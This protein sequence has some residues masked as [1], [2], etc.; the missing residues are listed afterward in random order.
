MSIEIFETYQKESCPN[1]TV[2]AMPGFPV[3]EK[4]QPETLALPKSGAM[5]KNR[6]FCLIV[7][8][9]GPQLKNPCNCLPK[10]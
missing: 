3:R 10:T 5:R 8:V 9:R 4:E 7:T 1:L 2:Y 6:R